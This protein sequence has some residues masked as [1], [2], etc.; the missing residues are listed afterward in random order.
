[1][2]NHACAEWKEITSGFLLLCALPASKEEHVFKAWTVLDVCK[3]CFAEGLIVAVLFEV[4]ATANCDQQVHVKMP[5]CKSL[6][7]VATRNA[8]M[9]NARNGGGE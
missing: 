2:R 5:L 7:M 4:V 8:K 1:M 6:A 9:L 3:P